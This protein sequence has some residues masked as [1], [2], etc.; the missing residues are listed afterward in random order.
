MMK[1][2]PDYAA[3]RPTMTTT[4]VPENMA[5]RPDYHGSL[6]NRH[7]DPA[8]YSNKQA[9]DINNQQFDPSGQVRRRIQ[10]GGLGSAFGSYSTAPIK[11]FT[12]CIDPEN[13]RY[14]AF[15]GSD[16]A[17]KA[18]AFSRELATAQ[19]LAEQKLIVMTEI[20]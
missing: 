15:L 10:E 13:G 1:D 5:D 17:K 7:Y 8:T 16:P 3:M 12:V 11:V 18:T 9:V 14:M 4:A 2:R 19:L 20:D 6:G